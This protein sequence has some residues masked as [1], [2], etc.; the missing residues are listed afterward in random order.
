M[1]YYGLIS[2]LQ[3]IVFYHQAQML[4]SQ[5]WL[6]PGMPGMSGMLSQMSPTCIQGVP[7]QYLEA[8]SKSHLYRHAVNTP[9]LLDQRDDLKHYENKKLITSL[10]Y[11]DNFPHSQVSPK[12]AD[13]SYKPS[14]TVD[15]TKQEPIQN[16]PYKAIENSSRQLQNTPPKPM[17]PIFLKTEEDHEKVDQSVGQCV[18]LSSP[19]SEESVT[20][21]DT[22]AKKFVG[23][24][25][26]TFTCP[27]ES[28]F[29]LF[30]MRNNT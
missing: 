22:K 24:N 25:Q 19:T 4:R 17:N 27:G 15:V 3:C 28:N 11:P 20:C 1:L 26:K 13:L 23:K 8:L 10:L 2:P 14:K 29:R 18:D 30:Q 5:T 12:P 9:S 16:A 7:F 21:D 6:H